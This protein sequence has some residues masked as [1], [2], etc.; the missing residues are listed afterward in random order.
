MPPRSLAFTIA[1][2]S[3]IKQFDAACAH[4]DSVRVSSALWARQ[5]EVWS[6]DPKTRQ[7]IANRLGWLQAIDFVTP[8]VPRLVAF[9]DSAAHDGF[10]EIVLLGMGGSS[11]APEE[12]RQV[13]ATPIGCPVFECSTPW[14]QT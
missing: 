12:L 14:I 13:S 7:L 4:L 9:A 5:L 10:A 8:L 6:S 3:L 2:G 11:L 1:P